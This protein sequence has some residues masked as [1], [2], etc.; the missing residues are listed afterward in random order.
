MWKVATGLVA[1]HTRGRQ[2]NSRCCTLHALR[3]GYSTHPWW[4]KYVYAYNVPS[5]PISTLPTLELR[6]RSFWSFLCDETGWSGTTTFYAILRTYVVVGGCGYR[7]KEKEEKTNKQTRISL[8]GAGCSAV[9]VCAYTQLVSSEDSRMGG[10][11][12][13]INLLHV[14]ERCAFVLVITDCDCCIVLRAWSGLRYA[15]NYGRL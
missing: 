14:C 13:L 9:Y 1:R 7:K 10:M 12:W 11:D 3:Y 4:Y 15:L 6:D 8:I 2:K 5:D